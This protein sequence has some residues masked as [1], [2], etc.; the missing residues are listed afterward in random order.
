M[1]IINTILTITGSDGTGESGIQA[2]I[3]TIHALGGHAVSVIT[4][5]TMQ[6]TLGIEQFYDLPADIVQGQL[7][8]LMDDVKPQVIKIGMLRTVKTVEAVCRSIR[9]HRIPQVVYDPVIRST[10]GEMLMSNEVA[11]AVKEQLLPLCTIVTLR[12]EAAELITGRSIRSTEDMT[13]AAQQLLAAGNRGV[14][15]QGLSLTPDSVT[16]LLLTE[17]EKAEFFSSASATA[18]THGAG[19]SLSSAIAACLNKGMSLAEAVEHAR[20]YATRQAAYTS[21]LQGR[22]SMLYNDF[23]SQITAHHRTNNDVR[24]YADRLNVSTRY[25]AQVTKRITGKLPKT[26]IDEYLAEEIKLALGSSDKTVQEIAYHFGFSSQA[27]FSRF[28]RKQTGHTPSEFRK[29]T[30][31]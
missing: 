2:D 3:R 28:F 25:L 14:L 5:V 29:I 26:L 7:D 4:S 8:I 18:H 16:D 6:N 31:K 24:F 10:R 30:H 22:G 9:R 23:L 21:V 17:E 15:L 19:N 20:A 13:L 12:I 1:G 27:Q 11:E